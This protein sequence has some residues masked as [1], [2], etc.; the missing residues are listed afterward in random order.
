MLLRA[1]LA[2]FGAAPLAL[3]VVGIMWIWADPLAVGQGRWL[4][5]AA[6]L[7]LIELVLLHSGAFMAIGPAVSDRRLI[8]WLWFLGFALVYSTSIAGFALWSGR[9]AMVWILVSVMG[10]RLVAVAILRDRR[11]IILMLQRSLLGVIVLLFTALVLVIPWPPLGIDEALR[12]EAFGPATDMVSRHPQR[13]LAWAALYFLLMA[14]IEAYCGWYMPDFDDERVEK[15]W[16][17]LVGARNP[18]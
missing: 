5:P 6:A 18:R 17:A 9:D 1:I 12:E 15:T 13:L 4:K 11:S 16:K 2:F 10:S 8:Q 14:V 3:L 7:I